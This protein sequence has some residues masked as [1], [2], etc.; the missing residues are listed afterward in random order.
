[1]P[2]NRAVLDLAPL[3]GKAEAAAQRRLRVRGS[4]ARPSLRHSPMRNCASEACAGRNDRLGINP[5]KPDGAL[6]THRLHFSNSH[7][8]RSD[9]SAIP[10]R[11]APEAVHES[12]AQRRAWGMPGAR[13]TRSLV[14]S[15]LVAHECSHHRSTG[16]PG[17]PCAMVLTVSFVLSPVIGYLMHTSFLVAEL[18]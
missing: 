1:M 11:D 10:R 17:I 15:V 14:C 12:S 3:A 18:G 16:T 9:G 13:C 6:R 7:I 8:V 5:R 4:Q 2:G